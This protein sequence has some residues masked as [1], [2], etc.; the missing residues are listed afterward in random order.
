M[1]MAVENGEA[2]VMDTSFSLVFA[3]Q[4]R[5]NLRVFNLDYFGASLST[6]PFRKDFDRNVSD[7]VVAV[8]VNVLL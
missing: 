6:F 4:Q 2:L 8:Q 1:F 5:C 3:S 7:I